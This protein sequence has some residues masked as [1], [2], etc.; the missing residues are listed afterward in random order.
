MAFSSR[1]WCTRICV[2]SSA[3]IL[4]LLAQACFSRTDEEGPAGGSG[5]TGT[6]GALASGGS[7][8]GGAAA[9]GA[10][11]GGADSTGGLGGEGGALQLGPEDVFVEPA[12]S[13]GL[14]DFR[15]APVL[16]GYEITLSLVA[17]QLEFDGGCGPYSIAYG[18]NEQVLQVMSDWES[19]VGQCIPSDRHLVDSFLVDFF[20]GSP[21]GSIHGQQVVFADEESTL[22]F[23]PLNNNPG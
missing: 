15:G 12:G 5:G 23:S 14:T 10:A 8:T 20:D 16:L 18:F 6:G 22:V 9:G 4:S 17:G 19:N 11:A 13:F 2:L 7:A 1:P 3:F 21:L